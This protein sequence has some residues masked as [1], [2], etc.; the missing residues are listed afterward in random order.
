MSR[1]ICVGV[2]FFDNARYR[3][4]ISDERR[5]ENVQSDTE[6]DSI[7]ARFAI[8]LWVTEVYLAPE[9]FNGH[10]NCKILPSSNQSAV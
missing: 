3:I 5:Q 1:K 4:C 2:K 10:D 8:F 7:G 9:I 6:I